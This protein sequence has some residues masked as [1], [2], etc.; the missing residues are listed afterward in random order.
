MV[1]SLSTNSNLSAESDSIYMVSKKKLFKYNEIMGGVNP[2]ITSDDKR[3][4]S[5]ND[6]IKEENQCRANYVPI[7]FCKSY[8]SLTVCYILK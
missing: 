4:A 3:E 6:V 2:M 8:L 7:V 1:T 5:I